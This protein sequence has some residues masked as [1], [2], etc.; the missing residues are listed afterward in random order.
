M[1][2]GTSFSRTANCLRNENPGEALRE[3]RKYL[4]TLNKEKELVLLTRKLNEIEAEKAAE[5]PL[6]HTSILLKSPKKMLIRR[7]IIQE[8][9]FIMPLVKAYSDSNYSAY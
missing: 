2:S 1:Q 5:F 8:S 4:A 7:Q 3:I 6:S 9:K